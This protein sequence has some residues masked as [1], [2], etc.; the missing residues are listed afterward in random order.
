M[1]ARIFN[2]VGFVVTATALGCSNGNPFEYVPV[3]GR[4]TYEDGSPIPAKGIRLQFFVQNVDPVDGA[5]PRPAAAYVDEQGSFPLT[6][7][8]KYGDGL[9]PGTHKVSIDY[10][11]DGSGKL[12]VPKEYVSASTTP[13]E[14]VVDS[15]TETVE[16][17]VPRP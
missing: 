12:L 6:T 7:S 5:Y 3:S 16:L 10:A 17:K 15:S 4:I 14:V 13:L 8:Y 1:R 11:V 2:L 9:M